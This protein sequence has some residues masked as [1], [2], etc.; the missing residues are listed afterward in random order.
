MLYYYVRKSLFKCNFNLN[1]VN[2]F[3]IDGRYLGYKKEILFDD[4]FNSQIKS[5]GLLLSIKALILNNKYIDECYNDKLLFYELDSNFI[6]WGAH[7]AIMECIKDDDFKKIY[8][9]LLYIKEHGILTEELKSQFE[10]DTIKPEYKNELLY[11]KT[12]ASDTNYAGVQIIKDNAFLCSD[13]EEF[14]VQNH[15]R[16]VG[17]FA[18]AYC[19]NLKSIVF[20]DKVLFG[21][22]PI[23][24]C[25]NLKSIVVKTEYLDYYK[26]ALPYYKAIIKD[27]ESK[28]CIV[29][30][31]IW[32]VFDKKATSYKY[33]WFL[34][35]LQ[36]YNERRQTSIPYTNI[37]AKMVAN[38]WPYVL[39][40]GYNFKSIDQLPNYIF[41]VKN[42]L[43][44]SE[45]SSCD[46]IES[47][48]LENYNSLGL[49][50]ILEPLIKN[51]PYRFLS[52][53]IPF[54]TKDEVVEK[55]RVLTN[56]CIYSIYEDRIILNE[57]WLSFLKDKCDELMEFT[58]GEL[59]S[60][61]SD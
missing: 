23:V 60:Y 30:D 4:I 12:L 44:L 6:S 21:K 38:A 39:F 14:E 48:V 43:S 57:N 59:K 13:I 28:P 50:K 33:F 25:E 27:T 18:F 45:L 16:Y 53:W 49:N 8:N 32:H 31:N 1:G 20:L 55:S 19:K 47:A 29:D 11:Y 58:N 5:I 42:K 24:E 52:P 51:V 26:D 7:C 36:I 37:I 56:N 22:F 41:E 17:D 9:S 35:I 61:L 34:S 15:V 54:S 3:S 2:G 10:A 40:K 46:D